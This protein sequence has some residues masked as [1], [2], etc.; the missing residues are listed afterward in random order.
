MDR[1]VFLSTA[2]LGVAFLALYGLRC[3]RRAEQVDVGALVNI[4]LEAGGVVAGAFL[5]LSTI[6]PELRTQLATVDIYI[7]IS[8]LVVLAVSAQRLRRDVWPAVPRIPA[9]QPST[10][11][12][13]APAS[14]MQ[15]IEPLTEKA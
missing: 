14:A 9:A 7:F 10:V 13:S 1:L 2:A 4:M 8:G 5:I 15:V 6:F 3:W 11:L 12:P